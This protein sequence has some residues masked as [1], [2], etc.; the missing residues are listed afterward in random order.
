MPHVP[1]NIKDPDF[2]VHHFGTLIHE[3]VAMFLVLI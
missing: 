3:L 1:I 2:S